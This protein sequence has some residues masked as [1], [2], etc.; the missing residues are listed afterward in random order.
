MKL[1]DP[2]HPLWWLVLVAVLVAVAAWSV[3]VWREC[4]ASGHSRMYCLKMVAR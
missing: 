1:R 3:T 4:R 2:M